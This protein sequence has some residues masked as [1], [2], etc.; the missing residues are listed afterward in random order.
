MSRLVRLSFLVLLVAS[1]VSPAF[2]QVAGHPVEVSAAGGW[3]NFDARDHVKDA[4]GFGG[5]IGYR[6]SSALTF[7]GT[8]LNSPTH[9]TAA[10]GEGKHSFSW[11][12]LDLRWSLRDPSEKVSP[13]L[14][15]G[16]GVGRSHDP[17][18]ALSRKGA[19]SIGMGVA[20]SLM[21]RERTYLR[22]QVRDVMLRESGADAFSNH[23]ETS[24]AL[25]WSFR[26]KSKD[27][28]L[29][30]VRNWIDVSPATPIG[31]K[32]DAQ[33]RPIDSDGDGVF[34]GLDKCVGTPKGAKVDK[35]GCPLDADGDGVADGIDT[36][37]NTPKGAKV[38]AVG[39]PLDSDADGV[40][41]GLDACEG[42]PKGAVVDAKG[43]PVDSDG[44]G[45][46][47]GIDQCPSTPSGRAVNAAGC[48][49]EPTA[50]EQQMLDTGV[51]RLSDL[52]FVAN[53]P[54]LKP[55]A[56]PILDEVATLLMQYPTLTFEIGGHGDNAVPQ[57]ANQKLTEQR[58]KGVLN[59]LSQKFP[60]LD[61][62]KLSAIGYG[63]AVPVAPNSSAAGRARNRRIEFKVINT[64]ELKLE[65]TK[66]GLSDA[67]VAP[68]ADTTK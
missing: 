52:P 57:V 38:D 33:G 43:C 30:G 65:R 28:D 59:Y 2:A 14:I 44:D 37:P 32:V 40:F 60:T 49:T 18:Q 45:V 42:T 20:M 51:I 31:A 6:W 4:V 63:S 50:M 35:N 66:R 58:A 67:S 25:Q 47:D 61:S 46:A 64:D 22:F 23:L 56:L 19:P 39:C 3:T 68:P 24:V 12:G 5:S 62:S 1:A 29:D 13:Y 9:R 21:G 10:F 7:E 8:Y 15:T 36:C 34:D 48:P 26:G 17:G 41:D 55:E 53:K 54:A 27:A 11:L 16:L